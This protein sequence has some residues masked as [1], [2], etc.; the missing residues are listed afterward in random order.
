[1]TARVQRLD[2]AIEQA[3]AQS[4]ESI[5]GPVAAL[6]SIRGIGRVAAV[7][8]VTEIGRFS[9]FVSPVELMGY[10]GLVPRQHSSG[11]TV[12]YGRITKTG[13][14]HLRRVLVESA[15]SIA[16]KPG[17]RPPVSQPDSDTSPT[18]QEISLKAQHRLHRR[19]WHLQQRGKSSRK[20]AVAIARELLGFVWAVGVQTE[21]EM[22]VA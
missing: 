4:P 18:V 15:W 16:R 22:A 2:A 10:S 12:R 13:N 5:G 7:T 3:V 20:I 9:R 1:M 6:Q 14:A 19:Y 11:T 17:L 8:L 21:R